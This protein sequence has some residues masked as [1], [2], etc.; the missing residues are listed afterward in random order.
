MGIFVLRHVGSIQT[1]DQTC[2]PCI[3]RPI[4]NHW[5]HEGSPRKALALCGHSRIISKQVG[6]QF[7]QRNLGPGRGDED[8]FQQRAL[9][10]PMLLPCCL[11][12][13]SLYLY[14]FC[15]MGF[16]L[17]F[18]LIGKISLSRASWQHCPSGGTGRL[19][20]VLHTVAHGKWPL[21]VAG[22]EGSCFRILDKLAPLIRWCVSLSITYCNFCCFSVLKSHLTLSDP[23]DCSTPGFPVLHH[24]PEFTQTQVH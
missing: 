16:L 8:P 17:R 21:A 20:V 14:W 3:D 6:F 9:F 11:Q 22:V 1:R 4:L 13:G 12:P 15:I 10:I 24:L 2:V 18:C 19:C 7:P 23:M 5:D